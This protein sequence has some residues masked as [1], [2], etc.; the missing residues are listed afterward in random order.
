MKGIANGHL[1]C[2]TAAR[3]MELVS[4][5]PRFKCSISFPTQS[6]SML[7]Y[8]DRI[9]IQ[10]TN[11]QQWYAKSYKE[12][13]TEVC[14][15]SLNL[16]NLFVFIFISLTVILSMFIYLQPLKV[17]VHA[18]VCHAS[19]VNLPPVLTSVLAW[20][21]SYQG[22]SSPCVLKYAP[23]GISRSVKLLKYRVYIYVTY[24]GGISLI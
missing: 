21:A 23:W 12:R 2:A 19:C 1:G 3:N 24:L 18:A 13:K 8:S 4:Y 17:C 22:H 14:P 5:W 6:S 9:Y 11:T 10:I 15:L 7:Y 16:Y 20:L